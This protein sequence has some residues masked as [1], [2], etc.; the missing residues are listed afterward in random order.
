MLARI[1]E[2]IFFTN[3]PNK[4]GLYTRELTADFRKYY[5][6]AYLDAATEE[7]ITLASFLPEGSYYLAALD[8]HLGW[9]HMENMLADIN[10]SIERFLHMK[11]DAATTEGAKTVI[12][13]GQIEDMAAAI[14]KIR[15]AKD[16][17]EN[18]EWEEIDG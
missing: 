13:P 11:S 6:V 18:G 10:D 7:A 1:E 5:H 17:I 15:S 3:L 16:I 9:S 14:G 8:K 4:R 12:R 2:G